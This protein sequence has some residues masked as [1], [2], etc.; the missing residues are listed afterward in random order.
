MTT[1]QNTAAQFDLN[2]PVGQM[3][4]EV[5]TGRTS[6]E[7]ELRSKAESMIRRMQGVLAALDDDR[8]LNSLGEVQGLGP[9]ID[10]LCA[11]RAQQIETIKRLGWITEQMAAQS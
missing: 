5:T 7:R 9:D 2:T 3:A 11:L 4:Y 8:H 6:T 1:T 10:R